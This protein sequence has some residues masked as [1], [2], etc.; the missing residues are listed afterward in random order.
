MTY[1]SVSRNISTLCRD[2]HVNP[3][4]YVEASYY[5]IFVIFKVLYSHCRGILVWFG[6]DILEAFFYVF[7]KIKMFAL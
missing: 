7:P 2:I 6:R 1:Y 4:K 5:D 3:F